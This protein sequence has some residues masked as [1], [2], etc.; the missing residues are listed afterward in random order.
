M[1]TALRAKK[2]FQPRR[3]NP[4]SFRPSLSALQSLCPSGRSEQSFRRADID[5][6]TRRPGDKR[7]PQTRRPGRREKDPPYRDLDRGC[8][9]VA[10][11]TQLAEPNGPTAERRVH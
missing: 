8:R 6:Y 11:P 9:R 7:S 1:P 3:L 4:A 2:H 5:I 10:V